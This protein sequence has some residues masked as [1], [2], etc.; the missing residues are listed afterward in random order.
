[1]VTVH[2]TDP[3]ETVYTINAK[4]G[5]GLRVVA[6]K[7]VPE[8]ILY[9]YKNHGMRVLS[10]SDEETMLVFDGKGGVREVPNPHKG[11][12]VLTNQRILTLGKA[13]RRL[14]KVFPPDRPLDI[15]WLFAGDDLYIVQSRP[16]VV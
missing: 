10:R 13:A 4:S 9:D 8:T 1:L 6:G 12:P 14:T 2:P 3:A 16:Y 11:K 5:L 7:K 15:E